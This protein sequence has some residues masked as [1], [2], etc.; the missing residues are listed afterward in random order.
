[1]TLFSLCMVGWTPIIV[2]YIG[3]FGVTWFGQKNASTQVF[4]SGD[5]ATIPSIF[6]WAYY[7]IKT[8]ETNL[9]ICLHILKK[10]YFSCTVFFV[11]FYT[12][13]DSETTLN[14]HQ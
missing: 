2:D 3:W 9:K 8:H 13:T 10:I 5:A 4:H 12:R 11:F 6:D 7:T 1:M 14:D